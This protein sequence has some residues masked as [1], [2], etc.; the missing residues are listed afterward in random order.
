LLPRW[1]V[2]LRWPKRKKAKRPRERG[3][4]KEQ[5]GAIGKIQAEY[6]PKIAALKAELAKIT[7]Q[8]DEKIAAVLTPEQQQK[9]AE[10]QAAAK[11]KR[12]QK[13]PAEGE[14]KPAEG[15]PGKAAPSERT[16]KPAN[17]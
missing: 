13:K 5:R 1:W 11:G 16:T 12:A 7:Q 3:H 6:G 2:I 14:K 10:L 8:R 15:T 17:G 4:G 9:I